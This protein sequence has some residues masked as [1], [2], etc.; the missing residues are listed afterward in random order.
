MRYH[1][2]LRSETDVIPDE[3]G[4]EFATFAAARAEARAS[5]LDI[6]GEDIRSGRPATNWRIEIADRHGKVIDSISLD[7]FSTEYLRPAAY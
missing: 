3:E 6:V 2:N 1:F 4:S 5:L 7:F